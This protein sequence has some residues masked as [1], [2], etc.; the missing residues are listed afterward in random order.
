MTSAVPTVSDMIFVS[1]TQLGSSSAPSARPRLLAMVTL[2]IFLAPFISN[3]PFMAPEPAAANDYTKRPVITLLREHL[4]RQDAAFAKIDE[5]FFARE[6]RF[7]ELKKSL[8]KVVSTK[9]A[10]PF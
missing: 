10:L 2:P 7:F 1:T 4:S 9:S 8:S 5:I 3:R 6:D